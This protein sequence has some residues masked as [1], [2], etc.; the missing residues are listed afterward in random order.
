MPEQ[1]C[2]RYLKAL[3]DPTRLEMVRLLFAEAKCVSDLAAALDSTVATTSYH[4]K[5]LKQGGIVTER[6]RGQHIYYRLA[7]R[8][9]DSI[10]PEG[11]RL[12]LGCCQLVFAEGR[13]GDV[14]TGP[15]DTAKA[16]S[17]PPVE[18]YLDY[19]ATTPV[20]PAVREAMLPFL[21]AEYANP[22]S[23]HTS[24]RRS[25]KAISAAR[26]QVAE[27]IGAEPGEVV[28][29]GGGTES[30]SLAIIGS[31]LARLRDGRRGHIITSAIEH[32]AVLGACRELEQLGFRVTHVRPEGDF[33][34]DPNAVLQAIEDD[35]FLITL[36]LV[37]NETGTVQPVREIARE[38]RQ[39]GILVHTD[40]VQAVGKMA[41]DVTDL[42][43]DLLSVAAH[44][45][46][47]PKGVG[48]LFIRDGVAPLP[49]APGHQENGR[50]GGTENVAGIVGFGQAAA[51]ARQ[52]LEPR[53]EHV[54]TLRERLLGLQDA[55]PSVRVNG[56]PEHQVPYI[57]NMCL[58]Y[59]DAL[60]LQTNLSRRGICISV[61]SACAS[62]K[63]EPSYVL[64]AA[65]MSDFAAFCSV[66]FSLG[67]LLTVEDMDRV[68]GQVAELSTFLREIR[69]PE[70]IGQCDENCPCLWE[71][72]A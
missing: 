33:R 56:H 68:V 32:P 48:A 65:G 11:T 8:I 19:A 31:A 42:G 12:D 25:R 35:T 30:D 1:R 49:L 9:R 39:R 7:P 4:L 57:M 6:R 66:R 29:T 38:A 13:G 36:M 27:L 18:V 37:N 24:G 54:T 2:V 40:A 64:R 52:E 14:A 46:Y 62:G 72:V 16:A 53:R 34:L 28:L 26:E 60:L 23:I 67:R 22:S 69:T 51:L 17:A 55:I 59:V 45:F 70:E 47:G 3:A 61:G 71:G 5:A 50:R 15:T 20:H 58:V 10:D 41:V 63:L 43:V 21:D 44:K